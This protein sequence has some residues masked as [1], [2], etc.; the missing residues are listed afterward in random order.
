MALSFSGLF[1]KSI[2]P[3]V[4][5]DLSASSVKVVELGRGE[6]L[7]MRLL[8]Y[9]IEP[10][11]RGAIVDGAIE[12][13][14]A[15]A[16]SLRTALVKAGFK[17]KQVAL[18][19]PSAAVITKKINLAG[20]LRD[21][22]YEVQVESEASQYIPFP[23]E[24][25]NLDFQILGPSES[26]PDE[27]EVLLAASRREK[28]EDRV[29]IAE[30]AGTTPIVMDVEPYA[31]R[32]ALDHV[33]SYL[34]NAG[35]GQ[36]VAMVLIGQNVTYVSIVL[37]GQTIFEREQSL[38]GNQLTQDI[39]RM[40]GVTYEEAEQKKRS[41]DLPDSYDDEIL[42][43]FVEQGALDI[44]RTLQFFFTS[45][46]YS[47]VDQIYLAGGSSVLPGLVEAVAEQT[48]VPTELFSPFQGMEVD[49]A[50]R[51]TQLRNDAPALMV[52]SG[53]AMRRFDA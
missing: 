53:L 51:E 12:K 45:T 27:V 39:V 32:A 40:Y 23:I 1:K 44:S 21:E 29:A 18:A 42:R 36:I 4:G 15:V 7:P 41:G 9:A 19:L 3:L 22:D 10:V 28:V 14:E 13:P 46:P 6:R 11:E 31:I 33:T 47:R 24:E 34:P 2:P 8:R 52:A 48:Q 50:I 35:Q 38:G 20:D 17:G 43:P 16:D 49:D 37:N 26:A 5:V 25:V 30:M